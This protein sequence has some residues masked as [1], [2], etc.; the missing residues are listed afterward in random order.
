MRIHLQPGQQFDKERQSFD[1]P[2]LTQEILHH[3]SGVLRACEFDKPIKFLG[4]SQHYWT[5]AN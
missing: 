3:T 2:P 4:D 1:F 5:K